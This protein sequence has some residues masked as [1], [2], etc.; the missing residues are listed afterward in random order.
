MRRITMLF[1][2]MGVSA[3][4]FLYPIGRVS[5]ARAGTTANTSDLRT[6]RLEGNVTII[7]RIFNDSQEVS[8]ISLTDT[9]TSKYNYS[10]TFKINGTFNYT[11]LYLS[12][13]GASEFDANVLKDILLHQNLIYTNNPFNLLTEPGPE[14]D[15]QVMN[16]YDATFGQLLGKTSYFVETLNNSDMIGSLT[17]TLT[18]AKLHEGYLTITSFSNMAIVTNSADQ[19]ISCYNNFSMYAKTLAGG[20]PTYCAVVSLIEILPK[21]INYTYQTIIS[22]NMMLKN[23]NVSFLI[24]NTAYFVIGFLFCLIAVIPAMIIGLGIHYNWSNKNVF[25]TVTAVALA[26]LLFNMSN[27]LIWMV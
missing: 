14:Q 16:P 13:N 18:S 7:I 27:F 6:I 17:S 15:L 12:I 26:I 22:S 25:V 19:I 9:I 10:F 5:I 1:F 21:N 20:I 8:K 4:L 2:L 11:A 3:L 24:D 23:T